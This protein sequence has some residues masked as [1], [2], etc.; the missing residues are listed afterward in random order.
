MKKLLKNMQQ[1]DKPDK[2][3]VLPAPDLAK[4]SNHE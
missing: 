1:T 4:N 3:Q 2:S